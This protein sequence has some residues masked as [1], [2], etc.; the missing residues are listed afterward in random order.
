[1][2]TP[3]HTLFPYATLFGSY[4]IR[5]D[6]GIFYQSIE[7]GY[8]IEKP[9][10]WLRY[11]NP[12]DIV[13]PKIKYNIPFR[14]NTRAFNDEDGNLRFVWENTEDALAVAYDTPVPG[15]KNDR[16]E[17]HCLNSSHVAI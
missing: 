16:S 7:N 3:R 15:F 14:G 12:W 2:L 17:E 10:L 6:Y 4:G 9:D 1:M 5:Y 11:G 8:Q 13:R